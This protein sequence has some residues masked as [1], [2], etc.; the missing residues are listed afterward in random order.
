MPDRG[1]RCRI[2]GLSMLRGISG[3]NESGLAVDAIPDRTLH[4]IFLTE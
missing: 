4:L 1:P 2:T 3:G